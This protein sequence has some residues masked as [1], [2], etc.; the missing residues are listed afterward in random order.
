MF[1]DQCPMTKEIPITNIQIARSNLRQVLEC[2]GRAVAATPLLTATE[3]D[4]VRKRVVHANA[5][6]P[7][8][9]AGALHIA[10]APIGR[11][12]LATGFWILDILWS[13]NIGHW[14]F[15]GF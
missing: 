13:L 5:P 11:P 10:G 1:N 8:R 9:S 14:S 12:A 2:G 15:P 7:L 4:S 3:C 6:S